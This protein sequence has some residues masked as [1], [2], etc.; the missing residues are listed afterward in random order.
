V[1]V[2]DSN[3]NH[4]RTSSIS[5]DLIINTYCGDGIRQNPNSEGKGGLN[6]SGQEQCDHNDGIATSP[7]DSSLDRQYDCTTPPRE[8]R[9]GRDCL[10]TCVFT[11]GW[12]GDGI[13]QTQYGEECDDGNDID[14]D[15]C[16]TT[17]AHCGWTCGDGVVNGGE[18]CDFNDPR[19]P[20]TG[21]DNPY[22]CDNTCHGSGGW[23]GDHILQT[24]Y[25]ELCEGAEGVFDHNPNGCTDTCQCNPPYSWSGT[26]C[27]IVCSPFDFK[28]EWFWDGQADS[29]PNYHH[30]M[31]TPV[32]ADLNQDGIPE[33]IFNAFSADN[34]WN[35]RHVEGILRV[36][37]GASGQLE[38]DGRD[39]SGNVI[40]TRGGSQIA[41]GDIN[42]DGFLEIVTTENYGTPPNNWSWRP[43]AFDHNGNLLW[44]GPNGYDCSLAMIA[45]L[46]S[47]GQAE[48]ICDRV[49]LNS[50]GTVKWI[51]RP[52]GN[53]VAD[54]DGDGHPEVLDG[55]RAWHFDG[56]DY[57][58]SWDHCAQH[59]GGY[60]AVANIDKSNPN[61]EIVVVTGGRKITITSDG[62]TVTNDEASTI[63]LFDHNGNQIWRK[64]IPWI[65]GYPSCDSYYNYA[66]HDN[67]RGTCHHY[68]G[69]PPTIADF[70]G[71]G[72]LEIGLAA[73]DYYVVF[74]KGGNVV[75]HHPNHDYSSAGTGSSVFDFDYNGKAEVLYADENN[76]MVF[77]GVSGNILFS[78]PNTSGTLKEYPVTV[79]VDGDGEVEIVVAQN[80]YWGSCPA[81][82]YAQGIRV[83]G[84]AT[85]NACNFPSTR[86]I[87]NQHAYHIT[88]VADNGAIPR[89]EQNNWEV[90]NNWRQNLMDLTKTWCGDL[91]C[92]AG[93]DAVSCPID[94]P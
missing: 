24:E 81:N 84:N 15:G 34:G 74:D 37:N 64:Q 11:G 93:E 62:I 28:V 40:K 36:L 1:R 89:I 7:L 55:C 57:V 21:P 20:G 9:A 41:V 68:G 50:D 45:D 18:E 32:V 5:F 2:T 38:F 71:D 44:R 90:F 49:I 6:D 39:G 16:N 22:E 85:A 75:W 73:A 12:C 47:D 92:D 83:F 23:C 87:W 67:N 26:D 61:P 35:S 29:Y 8:C 60:V 54:I 59:P 30:V 13:V 63:A 65:V 69:G 70:N 91:R 76:F 31:M 33:I 52:T 78:I 94:C 19:P 10:N 53:A 79:D 27:R 42:G 56:N 43:I 14:G 4:E 86:T 3:E 58:E 72:E 51:N 80:C 66:N 88:N 25:G 77:D 48:V 46:D 82:Y 17:S